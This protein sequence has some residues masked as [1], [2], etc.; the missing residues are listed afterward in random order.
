[1]SF[2]AKLS[3]SVRHL[4]SR[5]L[6]WKVRDSPQRLPDRL[7]VLRL[8]LYQL[9]AAEPPALRPFSAA[10][11]TQASS[12]RRVLL[13]HLSSTPSLPR[14]HPTTSTNIIDSH[15][16]HPPQVHL[17]R[18]NFWKLN[19]AAALDS[20]RTSRIITSVFSYS[21]AWH[22]SVAADVKTELAAQDVD[23][24]RGGT[25]CTNHDGYRLGCGVAWLYRR[26]C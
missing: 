1:M 25:I 13:W 15:K 12:C 6:Q 16:R 23:H 7:I 18:S 24:P 9:I 11:G 26:R 4:L 2:L 14:F 5:L 17:Y 8:C 3:P 21:T 22:G 10:I 19:H 20:P